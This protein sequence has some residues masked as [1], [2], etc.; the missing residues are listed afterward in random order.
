M[1]IQ[2]RNFDLPAG[3]VLLIQIDYTPFGAVFPLTSLPYTTHPLPYSFTALP[4]SLI[5]PIPPH[6]PTSP[7]TY[8]GSA[9]VTL[10]IARV[11]LMTLLILLWLCTPN[12]DVLITPPF[13]AALQRRSTHTLYA[14][15]KD[16]QKQIQL[17][18]SPS[19]SHDGLTL[20]STDN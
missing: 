10:H 8:R 1:L 12:I 2:C 13:G 14:A 4:S 17:Q 15:C 11:F 3:Y 16:G 19:L 20:E 7:V 9:C 6:L 5:F 18:L